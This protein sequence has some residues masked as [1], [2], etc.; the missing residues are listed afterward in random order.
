MPFEHYS[1]EKRNLTSFVEVFDIPSLSW[2]RVPTVGIPPAAVMNYSCANISDTFYYFGGRCKH[3]DDCCHNDVFAFST[4]GN[5]WN[6]ILYTNTKNT[7]MKKTGSGMI[8]FSS[9]NKD[10][11]LTI[12]GFGPTPATR[13][14]HSVYTPSPIVPNKM[15]TNEAHVLCVSSSPGIHVTVFFSTTCILT[16]L[17]Y[18]LYP[19][20]QW[21]V[22]TV[23]GTRPPPL[24][25]FTVNPLPGTNRAVI[26]GGMVVDDTGVYYT[27]DAY[28]VIYTKDLVVS[29]SMSL[30]GI[31][32][33]CMI[34]L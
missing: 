33:V 34:Y 28:L 30:N 24:A 5:K 8:S 1:D 6:A 15:Y 12:G 20:A 29:Y 17:L 2:S 27:N 4:T 26:F 16:K 25:W 21:T 14:S 9:D 18:L 13:P 11:L 3:L 19:I 7:P 32:V 23:T 22:P 31:H 10:Y